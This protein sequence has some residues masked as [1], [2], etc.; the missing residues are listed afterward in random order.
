MNT[1]IVLDVMGSLLIVCGIGLVTYQVAIKPPP[2]TVAASPMHG[3]GMSASSPYPGI[4]LA[5][6]GAALLLTAILHG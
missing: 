4:I 3:A 2:A 1:V 5:A 6:L